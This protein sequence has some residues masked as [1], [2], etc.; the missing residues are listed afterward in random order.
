MCVCVCTHLCKHLWDNRDK[1]A[2]EARTPR[3]DRLSA[4]Q[5]VR[6]HLFACVRVCMHTRLVYIHTYTHI[7]YTH[8]SNDEDRANQYE[9]GKLSEGTVLLYMYIH[10]YTHTH[11]SNDEDRANQYEIGEL[12]E[13]TVPLYMYIH[14]YTHTVPTTKTAQ[15]STKSASCRKAQCRC[16]GRRTRPFTTTIWVL[17]ANPPS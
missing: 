17:T 16:I 13:G 7:I 3:D 12:S 14:T 5:R 9:I 10:T 15:I 1:F 6:I 2:E 8:S 4:A 11:S